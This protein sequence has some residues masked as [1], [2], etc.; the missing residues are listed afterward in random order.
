M[1]TGKTMALTSRTFV[2]KVM[3]LL[4]VLIYVESKSDPLKLWTI[5]FS[6]VFASNEATPF[7]PVL[8]LMLLLLLL[9]SRFSCVRLCA[10]P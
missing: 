9:L 2:G 4:K 10:T 1:T 7:A 8:P 5:G 6:S 3:S